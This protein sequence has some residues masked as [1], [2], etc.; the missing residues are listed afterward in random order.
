MTQRSVNYLP[1]L[2]IV[3]GLLLVGV[4]MHDFYEADKEVVPTDYRT[5]DQVQSAIDSA[6]L[7]VSQSKDNIIANL[8]EQLAT[9]IVEVEKK[10]EDAVKAV[11]VSVGYLID[12]LS[13]G[14]D[15]DS[16][17]SRDLSDRE[18][19]TLLDGTVEFD[20]KDYDFEEVLNLSN[21][22]VLVNEEDFEGIPY[23]QILKDGI[24]YTVTFEDTLNTSLID[25]D[26]TLVFNFLG[27]EVEVSEW[28]GTSITFTKG[29]EFYMKE[30]ETKTIGDDVIV[31]KMVLE[32]KVKI[33]VNGELRS[34]N[35]GDTA[36]FKDLE[37]Y[38]KDVDYSGY[39]GG[40]FGANLVVGTDIENVIDSTDEYA[41]NSVWEY[42]ITSNSIGIVLKEDFKDLDDDNMPLAAEEKLCLPNEYV[43]VLYNGFVDE[44][45]QD[46]TFEVD[47]DYDIEV[48][49]E[50]QSG[51]NDYKKIFVNATG[52]FNDDD[53]AITSVM[54]GS[55][56]VEFEASALGI[57]IEDFQL[58]LYLNATNTT[59]VKATADYNW[60][61][62]FG[63]LVE[64]PEN[65][66]DDQEW[67]ITVPFEA[68]ESTITVL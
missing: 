19:K 16:D 31:V 65:S 48:R 53:E 6:K 62:D 12:K 32:D 7:E 38:V 2:A 34:I 26:E 42:V 49:G 18:I 8:T 66:I 45:T 55:S 39:A 24:T 9:K 64:D 22:E 13:I 68:R 40:Y 58:N 29:D 1:M 5:A 20:G 30:A 60:M 46:L 52:I 44:E 43:C 4:L 14:E 56:D 33:S 63:I 25:E 21:M 3:L 23:L 17:E 67:S 61:T 51:L 28:D 59:T 47:S 11:K 50:F 57:Q 54:I 35:K 27:E 36:K 15:I 10:V 37:I 41:D